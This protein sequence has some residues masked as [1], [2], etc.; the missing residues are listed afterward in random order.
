M[1]KKIGLLFLFCVF[2]ALFCH[3]EVIAAET[4]KITVEAE[5]SGETKMAAMKDAWT[6]AVRQAVGMYMASASSVKSEGL[7]DKYTEDIAAYSRGQVNSFETLSENQ[8]NGIWHIKI[9]ANVD[10]DV[11][12]ETVAEASSKS[13]KVDGAN[14]AAQMQSSQ[15]QKKDAVEVLKTSGLLDFKK[16][17]EYEPSIV[18]Y[19]I[20]GKP[21]IFMQHVLKMN[22]EKYTAQAQELEKLIA[23]IAQKKFQV[24]LSMDEAKNAFTL[25]R[26]KEYKIPLNLINGPDRDRM[27]E[28]AWLMYLNGS[29]L[30]SR[31]SKKSG[32]NGSGPSL[33][34]KRNLTSGD[35]EL[36]K[37]MTNS[38]L[39]KT[40][41]FFINEGFPD[42]NGE[43]PWCFVFKP[44]SAS[45]YATGSKLKDLPLKNFYN[46]SFSIDCPDLPE[47]ADMEISSDIELPPI[48]N[49]ARRYDPSYPWHFMIAP[50]LVYINEFSYNSSYF[51]PLLIVYQKIDISPDQ[52]AG[53]KNITGKYELQPIDKK[54]K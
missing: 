49:N 12:K 15:D 35:I 37:D 40:A 48:Y 16:C 19:E 4:E 38:N 20:N 9:K 5:G 25:L 22:L 54:F 53:L 24:K 33:T 32:R 34:N 14:L 23:Q 47:L 45:C 3:S 51:T 11:L 41:N 1:L 10:R 18:T 13:V 2:C 50:E 29:D 6:N 27:S 44:A 8:E 43:A 28:Q 42:T 26:Q 36:P 31:N 39:A 46:V 21:A 52:L 7:D 17:L 30:S